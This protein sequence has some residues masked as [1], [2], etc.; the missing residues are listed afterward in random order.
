MIDLK[1]NEI[2]RTF[3][4]IKEAK[5]SLNIKTDIG[6]VCSGKRKQAGG[7]YWKKIFI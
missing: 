7:Y 4:S 6:S 3:P 1:T 5:I 2:L